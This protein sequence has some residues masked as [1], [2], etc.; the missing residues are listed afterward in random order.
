MDCNLTLEQNVRA[1]TRGSEIRIRVHEIFNT[2]NQNW[3][4]RGWKRLRA[5]FKAAKYSPPKNS[6]CAELKD[7]YMV[8]EMLASEQ[9]KPNTR[10]C[11]VWFVWIMDLVANDQKLF[12]EMLD[13][14]VQ[15]NTFVWAQRTDLS[16]DRL[17]KMT[18]DYNVFV[19]RERLEP[20]SNF[21]KE[22]IEV[23]R[24]HWAQIDFFWNE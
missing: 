12:T 6:D 13:K 5:I 4:D 14:F 1:L 15:Q 23:M 7:E 18:E 19:R 10:W 16:D 11:H 8:D 2:N 9:H 20:G 24:K 3:R 22:R 21:F 17:T